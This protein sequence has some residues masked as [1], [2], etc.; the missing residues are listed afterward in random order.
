[1]RAHRVWRRGGTTGG[2]A[3]ETRQDETGASAAEGEQ[4]GLNMHADGS[5]FSFNVLLTDPAEFEGGG[6][7]F[8]LPYAPHGHGKTVSVPRSGRVRAVCAIELD[9]QSRSEWESTSAQLRTLAS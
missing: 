9:M 1:M 6:T 8:S 7:F 4:R 3:G 2:D 5:L